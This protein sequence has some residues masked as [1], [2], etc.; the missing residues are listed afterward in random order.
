M[1]HITTRYFRPKRGKNPLGGF[2]EDET[3]EGKGSSLPLDDLRDSKERPEAQ[4]HG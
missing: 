3:S 2:V 4:R 1:E